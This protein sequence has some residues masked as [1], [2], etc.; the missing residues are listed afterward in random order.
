MDYHPVDMIELAAERSEQAHA[1]QKWVSPLLSPIAGDFDLKYWP[2]TADFLE[3]LA[4]LQSEP[5]APYG[6]LSRAAMSRRQRGPLEFVRA[7]YQS[8]DHLATYEDIR[9]KL[10]HRTIAEITNAALALCEPL[11][12]ESIKSSRSYQRRRG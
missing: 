2:R 5:I 3:A 12:S 8:L 7:L 4:D 10:C 1:Y 6:E 9:V 11:T